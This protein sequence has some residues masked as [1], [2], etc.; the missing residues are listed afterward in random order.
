M[1]FVISFKLGALPNVMRAVDLLSQILKQGIIIQM[2]SSEATR[3]LFTKDIESIVNSE[4]V[5]LISKLML[6]NIRKMFRGTI[7]IAGLESSAIPD[8]TAIG[9]CSK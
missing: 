3:M 6:V 7:F 8:T 1:N 5:V 9:Q 4:R 2:L